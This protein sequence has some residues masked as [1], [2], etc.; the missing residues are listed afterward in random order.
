MSRLQFRPLV[1]AAFRASAL[2]LVSLATLVILLKLPTLATPAYWDEMAWARQAH[3]L[4]ENNLLRAL[5]GL[6]RASMFWGHPPGLH[7]TLAVLWK[8]FTPSIVIAHLLIAGFAAIGIC[9]TFLLARLLYDEKTAFFSALF[10]L[11]SPLYLAQS[12]MFLADIP[13][14][15]LGVLS[16]YLALT[17][18][19]VPYLL[20]ASYM[21][22]IKETSIALLAALIL[23]LFLI[24][25]PITKD[26]FGEALKYSV[27]LFIIGA[28]FILQKLTTG[29]FFFIYDFEIE[30]F[31]LSPH[32]LWNQFVRITEWIFLHQ[33]RYL[34]TALIGL[35]LL[36]N[37]QARR[38]RELWLFLL[39]LVLSGYSFSGLFFLPRYL[40]PVIPFFYILAGAALME[41]VRSKRLQTVAGTATL[42]LM[43]WSLAAQPLDGNAEYN[44]KYID[45]VEMHK[46]MID[47][48]ASEFP[49]ARTLTVWP[50][51]AE[52]RHP[53]LGYVRKP[54]N[55]RGFGRR[56]DLEKSD[57]ILVSAFAEGEVGKLG[58]LA[59]R[60]GWR[61]I[62]RLK[63]GAIVTE[64]YGR[65]TETSEGSVE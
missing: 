63:K 43:T 40:L 59:Q 23:Y 58:E 44:M 54:M 19:Y 25:K 41:L 30:L 46:A 4:S 2:P 61:P 9:G 53:L 52:M 11:L 51:T 12:G 7:L 15:A 8:L 45:V 29:H 14:A 36:L 64:L 62:K 35:N 34:F 31:H 60:S 16:V 49:E 3:W 10:L 33:H 38:R 24:A 37:P 18:R 28:F 50:H 13:V 48:I 65:A 39:I 56:A 55:A 32:S 57:L 42:C 5:P 6:R 26:T 1:P 47:H 21:V 17:G 20:C 22:L 27:P